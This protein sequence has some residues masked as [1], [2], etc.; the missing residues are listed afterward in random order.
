MNSKS[1]RQQNPSGKDIALRLSKMK[2]R[3]KQ[4][5]ISKL[6][7][8]IPQLL[9]PLKVLIKN[10]VTR[11]RQNSKQRTKSRDRQEGWDIGAEVDL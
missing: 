11:R 5:S 2:G 6:F 8:S 1:A 9:T 4:F 3:Y 7:Q 10:W